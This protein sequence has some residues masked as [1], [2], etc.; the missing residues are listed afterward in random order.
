MIARK[1]FA[2]DVGDIVYSVAR[3]VA[4]S[5]ALFD[6][7]NAYVLGFVDELAINRCYGKP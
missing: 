4:D 6:T 3:I 1:R 2:N 5:D 7:Y